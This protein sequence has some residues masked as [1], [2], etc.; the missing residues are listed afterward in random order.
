M[1]FFKPCGRIPRGLFERI[2]LTSVSILSVLIAIL[3][4]I[5]ACPG[6][7]LPSVEF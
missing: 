4:N 7:F 2:P 3:L 1:S 6:F 5:L